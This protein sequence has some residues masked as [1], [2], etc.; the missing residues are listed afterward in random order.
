MKI[1]LVEDDHL[2]SAVVSDSLNAHHYTVNQAMDGRTGLELAKA[3]EYDLVLLDIILPDMNGINLCKRLR[4]QGCQSPIL[5]LTAKDSTNDLVMGLDAGADDYVVK[6]FE[7]NELMARIR[8]LLRR[9]KQVSSSII[10]WENVYCDLKNNEVICGNKPLRLTPK[11]YC[12]LELFLLNPKR[13]FSRKAILD[14]LWDFADSPGEE[15]VST[16]IKCL[17]QK[18]KAGGASDPIDTVHGLGYRLRLPSHT[19][20][21]DSSTTLSSDNKQKEKGYQ[22]KVKAATAK[23]WEK[24]KDTYSEHFIILEEFATALKVYQITPQMRKQAKNEAHRLAGSLGIF[25]LIRGSQLAREIEDLLE[26]QQVLNADDIQ[27]ICELV[28]L[29]KNEL[30][31]APELHL[32][33]EQISYSPLI[34]IVDD[35]L[36]LAER[37]RIEAIAWGLRVEVATDLEVA[38]KSIVQTPPDVILLDL[39]FPSS[40]ESGLTL[41]GELAQRIPRIP[42]IAFSGRGSLTD[43]LEVARLGG[44]IF[45]QKPLS[46]HEILKVVTKVLNRNPSHSGD[47][48]MA[49]DDD[50]GALATLSALL[51]PSG[52]KVITL[53]NPQ[54]FWQ[55]LI[56]STPDL[57]ILDLEMPN[58]NGLELC[59]VV[60]SDP[61]WYRIPIVFWSAH[62][63]ASKID[64]AFAVG[65]DDYISKSVEGTELITRITRRLRRKRKVL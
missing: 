55:V 51:E 14:K 12:L 47:R 29:L 35:D 33:S 25:G 45:L 2:T 43:R 63:E 38:R 21:T 15:T 44:C 32:E 8:A 54:Q 11:E 58:L 52:L 62:T 41:L 22:K 65:A 18:F 7:I 37:I 28:K 48:V 9:G 57:L 39:N 42:V 13:I 26:S 19:E 5:L 30:Q 64:Q 17:R 31:K 40:K 59:Q 10:T 34:L 1:L 24:F 20:E 61:K 46:T 16:H 23:I 27:Q 6:P 53:N 50:E 49:V 36:K 3:F 56:N 4:S 60:R